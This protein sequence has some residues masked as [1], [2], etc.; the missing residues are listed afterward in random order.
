MKAS[1]AYKEV[2]F[3]I[4]DWRTRVF[5][6]CEASGDAPLGVQGWHAKDFP[7]S[8]PVA[9]IVPHVFGGTDDPVLWPQETPRG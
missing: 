7:P 5:V 2:R 3:V 1:V 4:E 8:T 9:D 6:L